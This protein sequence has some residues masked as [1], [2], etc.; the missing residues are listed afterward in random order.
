MILKLKSS[1]FFIFFIITNLLA[2]YL[3]IELENEIIQK[4]IEDYS[5]PPRI[6]SIIILIVV[7]V[8]IA[9]TLVSTIVLAYIS[10]LLGFYKF[11]INIK[12]SF[13]FKIFVVVQSIQSIEAIIATFVGKAYY[14]NNSVLFTILF[15]SLQLIT[16]FILTK[17]VVKHTK[18]IYSLVCLVGFF[19]LL[20]KCLSFFFD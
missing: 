11:D 16:L 2:N 7:L 17:S 20:G 19:F 10:S 6:Y 14:Q 15:L 13:L 5:I 3:F 8:Q 12:V 9:F 4:T 1:Y 18:F